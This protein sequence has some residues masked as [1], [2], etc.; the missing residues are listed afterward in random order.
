MAA[1][2]VS[3]ADRPAAEGVA[4]LAVVAGLAGRGVTVGVAPLTVE[5]EPLEAAPEPLAA[6]ADLAA[7]LGLA[8]R[9]LAFGAGPVEEDSPPSTSMESAASE[10]GCPPTSALEEGTVEEGG[11]PPT[12]VVPA[13]ASPI[14]GGTAF[15]DAGCPASPDGVTSLAEDGSTSIAADFSAPISAD[16]SSSLAKSPMT[17]SSSS[18]PASIRSCCSAHE[19]RPSL[20]GGA[21]LDESFPSSLE[22]AA[23]EGLPA[24]FVGTSPAGS[25]N[26]SGAPA[27]SAVRVRASMGCTL[28]EKHCKH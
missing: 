1:D 2:M 20:A 22:E 16:V 11:C 7:A 25:G 28:R 8:G 17:S 21:V 14:K 26:G 24:C 6:E 23:L 10:G 4:P 19:S 9:G 15:G 18:S 5:L 13:A 12:S 3:C 27:E